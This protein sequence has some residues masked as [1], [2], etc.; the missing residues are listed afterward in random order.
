MVSLVPHSTI[1]YIVDLMI[2]LQQLTTCKNIYCLNVSLFS[3]SIATRYTA[4][5]LWHFLSKTDLNS[6]SYMVNL[7]GGGGSNKIAKLPNSPVNNYCFLL[8]RLI[9]F[10]I[11]QIA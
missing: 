10:S 11:N 6:G 2:C 1:F 5:I 9:A 4:L 8:Y 3:D 7:K